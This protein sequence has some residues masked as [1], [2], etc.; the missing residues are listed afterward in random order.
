MSAAKFT[1]GPWTFDC[2]LGGRWGAI[3]ESREDGRCIADMRPSERI[4]HADKRRADTFVYSAEDVANAR[5]I[6][7]A[8]QLYA[9][10]ADAVAA[11]G[12]RSAALGLPPPEWYAAA[13][14]ALDAARGG[15]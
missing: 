12:A 15:E 10:L 4:T 3:N 5:L 14:T 13:V 9:A 6:A 7:V 1:P 8:P 2:A 11:Q